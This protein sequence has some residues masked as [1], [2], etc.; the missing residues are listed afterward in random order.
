GDINAKHGYGA[1]DRVLERI[2]ILVRQYFRDQDW[3]A[4]SSGD[5]F[6]VLLPETAREHAEALADRVRTTV[7]ERLELHDYRSD[8]QM[9]VTVSVGVLIAESV[10]QSMK[11][12]ELLRQA[13]DA[14]DRAKRAGRNRVEQVTVSVPRAAPPPRDKERMD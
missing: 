9:P 10:D 2:G 8:Q 6:S 13:K 7:S 1:G 14:V 5:S 3:V 4:R 11:A 12:E